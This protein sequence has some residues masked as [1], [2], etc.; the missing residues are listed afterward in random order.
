MQTID[1]ADNYAY[2][3]AGTS[4]KFPPL[5]RP[6]SNLFP[7]HPI[8]HR[9]GPGG[10]PDSDFSLSYPIFASLLNAKDPSEIIDVGAATVV[11]IQSLLM[12]FGILGTYW[13]A[14]CKQQTGNQNF[15][16]PAD[17][18]MFDRAVC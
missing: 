14:H 12:S 11:D 3:A 15:R 4:Y 9:R 16:L 5:L 17:P 6:L 7:P 18:S 10:H 8:P 1:N 13:L 2:I